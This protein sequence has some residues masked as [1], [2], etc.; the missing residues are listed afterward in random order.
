MGGGME[1]FLRV[2]MGLVMMRGKGEF[3]EDEG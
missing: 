3:F 1:V 2:T